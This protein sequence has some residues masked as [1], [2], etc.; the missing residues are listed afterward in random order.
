M[1]TCC[2]EPSGG[3]QAPR[4]ND[5]SFAVVSFITWLN[6]SRKSLEISGNVDENH[7]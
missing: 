3:N 4:S 7:G 5:F 1:A 2:R 6:L